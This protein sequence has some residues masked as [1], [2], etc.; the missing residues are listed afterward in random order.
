MPPE[1]ANNLMPVKQKPDGQAL[2]FSPKNLIGGEVL[3]GIILQYSA[4]SET[5]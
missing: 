3:H 4:N 1:K 5:Q 2:A